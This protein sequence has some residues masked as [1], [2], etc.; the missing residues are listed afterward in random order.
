[1][2]KQQR[3]PLWSGWL[4]QVD[5]VSPPVIR[6]SFQQSNQLLGM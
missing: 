4:N 6:S 3:P 1:L 2:T 5:D